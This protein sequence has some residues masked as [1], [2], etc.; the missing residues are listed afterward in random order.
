MAET[1]GQTRSAITRDI[2]NRYKA[3]WNEPDPAARRSAVAG[4]WAPDGVEYLEAGTKYRGHDELA[5]RVTR[6]YEAFVATGKYDIT[7]AG[8][9]A[10]HD[11]IIT[12]T[13]QLTTPGGEVDWAARVFLLIGTDGLIREDYQLTVKPLPA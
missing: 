9:V 13:A 8:D 11:D 3:V 4:L 2:V 7:S 12:F 5:E 1:A 6:A 10:R